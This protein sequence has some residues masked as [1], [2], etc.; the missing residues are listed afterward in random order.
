LRISSLQIEEV[1]TAPGVHGRIPTSN[2]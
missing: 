2:A 1:F